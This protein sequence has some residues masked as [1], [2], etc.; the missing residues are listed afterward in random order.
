M[1]TSPLGGLHIPS[2]IFYA[3]NILSA[4]TYLHNKGIAYR[5]LKPE[6]IVLDAKGYLKLTDFMCAKQL[7]GL[8]S[9]TTLCGNPGT[10]D[11]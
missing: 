9:A 1:G 4:L 2:C 8:D 11:F 7:I 10:Q 5:N 6:N 3:A